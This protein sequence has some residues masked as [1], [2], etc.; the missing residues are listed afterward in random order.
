[1]TFILLTPGAFSS[2][3]GTHQGLANSN[4]VL[5]GPAPG[6]SPAKAALSGELE[7]TSC[8]GKSVCVPGD[9]H[10]DA[11]NSWVNITPLN[12][13]NPP[14]LTYSSMAYNPV[15][16]NILLFGGLSLQGPTNYTWEF[17]DWAWTNITTY[18]P[19]APSPRY[20]AS[21][22]WDVAESCFVL[23]GGASS[24][25]SALGDTWEFTQT[26]G[27]TEWHNV[28]GGINGPPARF[29]AEMGYDET[30]GYTVLFGG[31]DSINDFNDTWMFD[32][33][34][35]TQLN[36]TVSPEEREFAT[37][38][39]DP[40][41]GY[42]IMSG[43]TNNP[44]CMADIDDWAFVDGNWSLLP[45]SPKP[46][47]RFLASAAYD[48]SIKETLLFGGFNPESCGNLADTWTYF[49]AT[50][51]QLP[52]AGP[53]ARAGQS[54]A[55]DTLNGFMV[56]FGGENGLG[57]N[58]AGALNDT[59][60]YGPWT[61]PSVGPLTVTATATPSVGAAP[62]NASFDAVA[63]GGILPYSFEWSWDDGNSTTVS[64]SLGVSLESH[65]FEQTGGYAVTVTVHDSATH[66]ASFLVPVAAGSVM[67]LDWLPPRDTYQFNNFGSYWSAG[68]NCYGISTTEILYWRHDI[69]GW[70]G[71]PY[72]PSV[73]SQTSALTPPVDL[74]DGLNPVTLA[75]MAHQVYDPGVT[76]YGNPFGASGFAKTWAT[77]LSWLELGQPV[78]LSLGPNNLHAVVLYGEQTFTNGTIEMDISDPNNPLGTTHAWYSPSVPSFFY[79][80]IAAWN[81]FAL[82]GGGVPVALQPDWLIPSVFPF[83]FRTWTDFPPN[84]TGDV[85]VA[86][87]QP[88][89][90]SIGT[91]TDSF[92][93]PGDSQ[94]FVQG[95]P[96]T[97][98]IAEDTDELYEL[99]VGGL[100]TGLTISDAPSAETDV[101]AFRDVG[102]GPALTVTGYDLSLNSSLPHTFSLG[103]RAGGFTLNVGAYPVVANVSFVQ[104][105][106]NTS[107]SLYASAL[108]FAAGSTENFTVSN[109]AGLSSTTVP[110][111]EVSVTPSGSAS[112][113]GTY[114]IVNGQVGLVPGSAPSTPTSP[115]ATPFYLTI[116]FFV[117]LGVG[118]VAVAVAAIVLFRVRGKGSS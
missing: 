108:D 62:F 10:P 112:P 93:A 99:P 4:P 67:V 110:A 87:D 23:F 113:S 98:G 105:I 109:W 40:A 47:D 69:L 30:D 77:M 95:I 84:T 24:G 32:G 97:I 63:T 104:M 81:G 60:V 80:H 59:W 103:A 16:G 52:I 11:G 28:F 100:G 116:G 55:F 89:D 91:Q 54:M 64:W 114:G 8:L 68:G 48:P 86:A 13:V 117:G 26:L 6:P 27:W 25:S 96:A 82:A 57:C 56:L 58:G 115:A 39:W 35:W 83:A 49:A 43:G 79:D 75:I 18:F 45:T 71:Q 102:S 88:V 72:L 34:N 33:T 92:T 74:A 36:P 90:V 1:V 5:P 65:I 29:G 12:T 2:P 70:W 94:S 78:T 46:L 7:A 38:V 15:D 14:R 76:V 53:G 17:H 20:Y 31:T 41:D 3:G 51:T 19:T 44:C 118:G 42:L 37:M 50:W 106:G 61:Q 22:V 73:A 111:L 21:L 9:V 66:S 107:V 101:Q 85:F